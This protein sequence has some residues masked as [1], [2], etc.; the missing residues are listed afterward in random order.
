MSLSTDRKERAKARKLLKEAQ[1][2]IDR[3]CRILKDITYDLVVPI[4]LGSEAGRIND[5]LLILKKDDLRK[6]NG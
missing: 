4:K 5:V 1:V 6:I 3:A 2:K